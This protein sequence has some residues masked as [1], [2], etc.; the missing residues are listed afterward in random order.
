MYICD[1]ARAAGKAF[2]SFDK[3]YSIQKKLPGLF[4]SFSIGNN[5]KNAKLGKFLIYVLR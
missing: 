1:A 2:A 5:A 3:T 4:L